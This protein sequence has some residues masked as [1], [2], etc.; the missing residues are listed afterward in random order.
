MV[1]RP[2][3]EWIWDSMLHEG[4]IRVPTKG[5]LRDPHPLGLPKGLTRAHLFARWAVGEDKGNKKNARDLDT[6]DD[7]TMLVIA[8]YSVY[9]VQDSYHQ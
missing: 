8:A 4:S 9:W 2:Y 6:V 5:R 7:R 1:S 3:L